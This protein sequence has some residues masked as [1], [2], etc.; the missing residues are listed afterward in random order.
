MYDERLAAVLGPQRTVVSPDRVGDG[1]VTL[2]RLTQN[3][4][5]MQR[6]HAAGADVNLAMQG[7]YPNMSLAEFDTHAQS[8]LGFAPLPTMPMKKASSYTTRARPVLSSTRPC[9]PTP[10][11]LTTAKME[12]HPATRC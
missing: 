8:R 6:A 5:A 12:R 1:A 2:A 11:H 7:G 9:R 10:P 4:A 3:A